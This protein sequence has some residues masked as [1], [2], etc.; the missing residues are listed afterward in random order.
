M[1]FKTSGSCVLI[2]IRSKDNSVNF[3]LLSRAGELVGYAHLHK[4]LI[5]LRL[6][7]VVARPG[8]GD[9]LF[10]AMSMY[11]Y[12]M[13][14]W[15]TPPLMEQDQTDKVKVQWSRLDC[16]KCAIKVS[17]PSVYSK[18]S[19]G[20]QAS[21]AYQ[22]V[23]SEVYNE[24]VRSAANYD[25]DMDALIDEGEDWFYESYSLGVDSSWIDK[26]HPLGLRE[27]I[28]QLDSIQ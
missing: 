21:N 2:A 19:G 23:P 11:A 12:T 13:S 18:L 27:P 4:E 14:M 26:V 22:M 7:E 20:S 6:G 28:M 5:N 17:M 25:I 16:D 1:I 8:F 3:A 24:A 15:F 10:N 9:V